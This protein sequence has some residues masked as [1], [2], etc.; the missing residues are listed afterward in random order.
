MKIYI[1]KEQY[2]KHFLPTMFR[3]DTFGWLS[4][5]ARIDNII[6]NT[7]YYNKKVKCFVNQWTRKQTV[8]EGN[9]VD[10]TTFNNKDTKVYSTSVIVTKLWAK[11]FSSDFNK[12]YFSFNIKQPNVNNIYVVELWNIS[13]VGRF[14][15]MIP[16]WISTHFVRWHNLLC[17]VICVTFVKNNR[18]DF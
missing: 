14:C 10:P 8:L 17:S 9:E 12:F 16:K 7:F 2:S 1:C 3:L 4:Q 11:I 15:V 18:W 6:E 13:S 5:S